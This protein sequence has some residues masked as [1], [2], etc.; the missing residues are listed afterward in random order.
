MSKIFLAALVCVAVLMAQVPALDAC[1]DKFLVGVR[2]G[3]QLSFSGVVH[4]TRILVYWHDD[5]ANDPES[6][7]DS[8]FEASLTEAGHTVAIV[9]DSKA[10]FQEASSRRFEVIMMEVGDAREEQERLE[11]ASPESTILP[12]LHFPTRSEYSEAKKEFGYAVKTP[13]TMS[14]L[15]SQIEKARPESR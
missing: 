13:T 12:V 6:A 3:L 7:S 2:G 8:A 5:P 15:L 14:K 10:L 11:G 9:K 1:G 4:P